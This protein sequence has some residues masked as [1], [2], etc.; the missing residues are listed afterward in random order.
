MKKQISILLVAQ[1]LVLFAAASVLFSSCIVVHPKDDYDVYVEKTTVTK[2]SSTDTEE[3][4][5]D[6]TT[7]ETTSKAEKHSITCKNQ[8][9]T[10]IISWCVKCDRNVTL[11][12]TG[13]TGS[14]KAYHED[15]IADLPEGY[16][17]IYF[18]FANG[19]NGED[20]IELNQD[21]TYCIMGNADS[22]TVECRSVK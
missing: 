8:T 11:P 12:N 19:Q 16:Y 20:S 22:Y 3:E 9:S 1:V 18:T 13:F 5:D 17:R 6:S 15:K 2:A 4:T 14:V 10:D 21:V 7:K